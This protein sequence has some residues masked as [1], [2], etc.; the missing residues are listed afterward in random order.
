MKI[1]TKK[2]D[3]GETDLLK[4]RVKKN[5]LH[6]EVNGQI[7]EIMATI[8]LAK[9]YINKKNVLK[10]LDKIHYTLYQ[11]AYEIALD[12]LQQIKVFEEDVKWVE[13]QID[14]FDESLEKLTKFIQLDESKAA[15]WLNMCRVKT[16]NA[17][18]KV[19]DL[20]DVKPVNPHTLKYLNRLSDFFFTLGRTF[21]D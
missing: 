14:M 4:R 10:I 21:Q 19:I 3:L 17:E 7:D 5:D 12:D 13:E 20:N 11:M 15:A 16:R 1:Y 8:L 6:I 2:G 9:Q 18:R